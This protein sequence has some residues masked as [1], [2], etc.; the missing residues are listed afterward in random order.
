MH[1]EGRL[2]AQ[3]Q[4]QLLARARRGLADEAPHIGGAGEGDLVHACVIDQ[5]GTRGTIT[6]DDV[7]HT[8]RQ[9]CLAADFGERQGRQ[10]RELGGLQHHRIAGGKGR[11][12]LPRQHQEREVPRDDLAADTDGLIARELI[13]DQ[14]RPARMV[15]EVTRHQRNVDVARLADGLAIVHRLQHREETLALLDDAGNGIEMLGALMAG[16]FRP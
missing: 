11:R 15:I 14:L 13:T 7:D 6:R 9:A 16:E 1:D 2:A 8:R 3:L 5:C 4:R 12:D 10:G